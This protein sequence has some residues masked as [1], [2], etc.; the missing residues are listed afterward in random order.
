MT[1]MTFG[2]EESN[3]L[4]L[5]AGNGPIVVNRAAV[6]GPEKLASAVD[7]RQYPLDDDL[8]AAGNGD[9]HA[10]GSELSPLIP[11]QQHGKLVAV[12][13]ATRRH[14]AIA[15][16]RPENGQAKVG[17]GSHHLQNLQRRDLPRIKINPL[18]EHPGEMLL[19]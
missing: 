12:L 13:P 7:V 17:H 9:I 14:A 11:F 15:G 16:A 5:T 4:E 3:A 6:I 1:A 10:P 18:L 8:I 2:I 19:G